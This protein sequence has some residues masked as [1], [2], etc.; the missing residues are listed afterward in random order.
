[1]ADRR[2]EIYRQ[3]GIWL[4]GHVPDTAQVGMLEA[5]IIGYYSERPVVDFAGLIQPSIANFLDWDTDYEDAAI[6]AIE[7]YQPEYLVL[8][9]G[10]FTNL[11]ADFL[12]RSCHEI[13]HLEGSKFDFKNDL[14]IY[15]CAYP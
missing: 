15:L 6:F 14:A 8:I 3:A 9:D 7:A 11:E 13:H 10:L 12:A 5:G 2:Y 4:K 1:L